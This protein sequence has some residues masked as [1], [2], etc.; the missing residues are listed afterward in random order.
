MH[1][2]P[3]IFLCVCK[4]FIALH[5]QRF[6]FW[7]WKFIPDLERVVWSNH[8]F[9][10]GHVLTMEPFPW[11]LSKLQMMQMITFVHKF[12]TVY[13]QYKIWPFSFREIPSIGSSMLVF[14][15]YINESISEYHKLAASFRAWMLATRALLSLYVLY[16]TI[17]KQ[18]GGLA[19]SISWA[20]L[21]ESIHTVIKCFESILNHLFKLCKGN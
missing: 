8:E 10:L 3:W 1:K 7:A 6:P 11:Q 15:H 20:H 13:M 17:A 5:T 19:F 9:D 21:G 4:Y 2:T 16:V 12:P 14:K 18:S